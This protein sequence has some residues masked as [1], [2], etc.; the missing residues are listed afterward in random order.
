MTVI[1][2]TSQ[3]KNDAEQEG[4]QDGSH[5]EKRNDIIIFI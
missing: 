4:C 3:Q 1:K 5:K 2:S